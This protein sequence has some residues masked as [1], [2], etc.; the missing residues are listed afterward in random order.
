[1]QP[2]HP[3]NL[4]SGYFQ[5]FTYSVAI[6]LMW[7]MRW[8]V[9][10][11]AVAVA[12]IVFTLVMRSATYE[13]E[14]LF[15]FWGSIPVTKFAPVL[16]TNSLPPIPPPGVGLPDYKLMPVTQP[17]GIG[18]PD[19]KAYSEVF[20]RKERFEIYVKRHQLES[21]P[22]VAELRRKFSSRNGITAN[23]KPV[24]PFSRAEAKDIPANLR[25]NNNRVTGI[26]LNYAHVS[27]E[28]AQQAVKLLGSYVMDSITY[29]SLFEMLERKKDQLQAD[30]AEL[31]SKALS[32]KLERLT[33]ERKVKKL[34]D[35]A[36]R[37]D[38]F[39]ATSNQ[40]FI[41]TNDTVRF[42]SPTTQF[43]A[44]E[45]ETIELN[46]RILADAEK[47]KKTKLL[48]E[49]NDSIYQV[50]TKTQ[51]GIAILKEL[52]PVRVA[53]FKDKPSDDAINIVNNEIF[54]ENLKISQV[55]GEKSKFFNEPTLPSHSSAHPVKV[56]LIGLLA[57]FLLALSTVL[58]LDWFRSSQQRY[59]AIS[60]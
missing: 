3:G 52:E 48:L 19:Y 41:V 6:K 23:I 31:D 60:Y 59:R 16:P 2:Q 36:S 58:A 25:E 55:Y 45:I 57:G 9:V 30:L 38:K 47:R 24:F 34:K 22:V 12:G 37:T 11:I 28:I 42:L 40:A 18:L 44:A 21:V 1:M 29:S 46:E 8:M 39:Q 20:L 14:G 26:K 27:P 4:Q 56:A 17:P 49:Y 13:S 54:D 7:R 10:V 33:L 35:L 32:I 5:N 51:S 50:A 43:M 53:L 15:V